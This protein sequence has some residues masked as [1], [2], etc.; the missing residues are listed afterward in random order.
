[1]PQHFIRERTEAVLEPFFGD[2]QRI[3]VPG[4]LDHER[5]RIDV[6]KSVRS[7][8][9]D[10]L[11]PGEGCGGPEEK[12]VM[13]VHG[14]SSKPSFLVIAFDISLIRADLLMDS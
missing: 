7:G 3:F 14:K 6:A 9:A 13:M 2:F 4:S 8:H 1:M 5:E 11:E 10:I 12:Y